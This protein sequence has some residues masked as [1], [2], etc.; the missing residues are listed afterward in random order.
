MN[1]CL[2]ALHFLKI[3]SFL[4]ILSTGFLCFAKPVSSQD[5]SISF[6]NMNAHEIIEILEDKMQI[7]FN[8][9]YDLFDQSHIS[10]FSA[11]GSAED[12]LNACFTQLDKDYSM[13]EEGLYV[14][15]EKPLSLDKIVNPKHYTLKLI[16][17]IKTDLA[18]SIATL[19]GLD[20]HYEA[21]IDG[22]ISFEGYF[23]EHQK[24]ILSYLG[25]TNKTITLKN[26]DSDKINMIVL[27]EQEH[28][29]DEIV[30]RD[31]YLT[32]GDEDLAGEIIKDEVSIG[33]MLDTD[34]LKR[35][36]MIAGVYNTT[37]SL[38]NLQVR[39]GLAGQTEVKWNNIQLYQSSLFMGN[40]G[41]INPFMT[42][43]IRVNK[44][45]GSA[46]DSGN[47][48]GSIHMQ[49][50]QFAKSD[51][52]IEL[53]SDLLYYNIGASHQFFNN[54]LRVKG[55]YRHSNSH[56]FESNYYNTLYEN[57]FQFGPI[58]SD[59]Y[60]TQK[61]KE[62]NP[63]DPAIQNE[64]NYL[65]E[66]NFGDY[67][68]SLFFK[69]TNKLM[70]D[71]NY[72]NVFNDFTYEQVDDYDG[73]D[74]YS[75]KFR[76]NGLSSK[77]NYQITPFWKTEIT[78]ANSSY[79]RNYDFYTD[80]VERETDDYR[81]QENYIDESNIDISQIFRHNEHEWKLGVSY[82]EWDVS[83]IDS[84]Q[85]GA[86][87]FTDDN[88]RRLSNERSVYLDYTVTL[89]GILKFRNGTR[90]SDYSLTHDNRI[91]LEPRIH[92]SLLPTSDLT[93]HAHYGK[94]HKNLN[95]HFEYSNL[96]V[97][98]DFWYLSDEG[99]IDKN[100]WLWVVDETQYSAGVRYVKPQ[101]SIEIEAY[102]KRVNNIWSESF[103]L[104]SDVNP[105]V[106]LNSNVSGLELSLKYNYKILS[107]TNTFEWM[108]DDLIF[109]DN[110]EQFK[111]PYVQ[112]FRAFINADL[113][114]KRLRL[115]ASWNFAKGR[116][117]SEPTEIQVINKN[118]GDRNITF[119]YGTALNKQLSDYHRLDISGFYKLVKNEKVEATIGLSVQNVYDRDNILSSTYGINW[120]LDPIDAFRFD[121]KGRPFSPN[122]S[123]H[124]V[125]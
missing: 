25:Y 1:E 41:S 57:V 49:S 32:F 56:I 14:I 21:D 22:K 60:W 108:K 95:R 87:I 91:F 2:P 76:N 38:S 17:E 50:D 53:F 30:I 86:D 84:S 15:K 98:P 37:E 51:S 33:G 75:M 115:S 5:Q 63:D 24:I 94:Y 40:V 70:V 118:E 73:L 102:K 88:I 110:S 114:I 111:S 42:D 113:N 120:T 47:S 82:E 19:E 11:S 9:N 104:E 85:Y 122:L 99:E 103:D 101:Y 61:Y 43:V 106:Y 116:Y 123:L 59:R 27:K 90:W 4:L 72:I 12:I 74:S 65:P 117:F 64:I 93:I 66:L 35:S 39:G 26:L 8:Y 62:Q 68:L 16:D 7:D 31:S 80:K 125:F 34:A 69:P 89:A 23:G 55:A 28:M 18:Y 52:E 20:R 44:N 58:Q 81:L 112:P 78:Y 71:I 54:K 92:V 77:L 36:Q 79:R 97:E 3:K 105:W 119:E 109:E 10:S 100:Y 96:E 29:L 107:L 6:S 13:L 46:K 45:G 48:A 83:Y 67:S 121:Q 124:V